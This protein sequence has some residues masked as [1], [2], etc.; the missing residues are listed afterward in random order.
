VHSALEKLN[1]L[2]YRILASDYKIL[3]LNGS[4]LSF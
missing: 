1:A 4:L 2:N 3:V